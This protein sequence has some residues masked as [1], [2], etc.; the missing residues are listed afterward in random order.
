MKVWLVRGGKH[1]ET[2]AL[3]LDN[4]E[5]AIG[6]SEV[7]GVGHAGSREDIAKMIR[8]NDAGALDGAII[9]RSAQLYAFAHRIEKGDLIV[10]P[11]KG[12]SKIAIGI[13]EAGYKYLPE[14]PEGKH[15]IQVTWN[16]PDVPRSSFKQDLLHSFGAFM[17]VC[18][19]KRNNALARI[20]TVMKG[21]V[22]PGDSTLEV[23]P[24][25]DSQGAITGT[26]LEAA[27]SDQISRHIQSHFSGHGLARLLAAIL[28]AD[29]YNTKVSPPGPDGGVDILAG[30][31]FFGP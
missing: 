9:N 22:D 17:T 16:A 3:S 10:M 20:E 19:I 25:D 7:A 1:G 24:S 23:E 21:K 4:G 15:S 31:G 18:Q 29:G 5:A 30:K 13:A 14:R 26:D 8:S 2:E 27:I 6:F 28:S 11:L 12:K